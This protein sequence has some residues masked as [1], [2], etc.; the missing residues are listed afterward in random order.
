MWSNI[1]DPT[2]LRRQIHQGMCNKKPFS[3][4]FR[5]FSVFFLDWMLPF[6]MPTTQKTSKK[7]SKNVL[8]TSYRPCYLWP[9][10]GAV[11][12]CP[13]GLVPWH[14]HGNV[15][16]PWPRRCDLFVPRGVSRWSHHDPCGGCVPDLALKGSDWCLALQDLQWENDEYQDE[17]GRWW[18]TYRIL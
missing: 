17:R 5:C 14:R 7:P 4:S 3:N 12:S 13:I 11:A 16:V 9:Q 18:G 1:E 2:L 10:P 6:F 8:T 15:A